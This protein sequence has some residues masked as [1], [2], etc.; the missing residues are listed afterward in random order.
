VKKG[1][2]STPVEELTSSGEREEQD[3]KAV[4]IGSVTTGDRV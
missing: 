2:L 3:I 4:E 1:F